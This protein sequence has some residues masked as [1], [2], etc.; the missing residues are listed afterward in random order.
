V[1]LDEGWSMF[2]HLV[3]LE[4]EE[5]RIGMRLKVTFHKVS[6]ELTLPLFAPA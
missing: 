5:A 3:G 4:I 6:D 2:S 1:D